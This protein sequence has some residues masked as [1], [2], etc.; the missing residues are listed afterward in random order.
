MNGVV[1]PRPHAPRARPAPPEKTAASSGYASFMRALSIR[2]PY[3]EEILR[4]IKTVEYRTRPTKIIDKRF[5]IYAGLKEP[6]A[7]QLARFSRLYPTVEALRAADLPKGL[8]VGTAIITGNLPPG[9]GGSGNEFWG[10]KLAKV[11]RMRRPRK[12]KRQ[13]QPTW[14]NPF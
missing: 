14:F 12:P 3:A 2:Q 4:G 10:W 1:S 5:Y 8:I 7:A 13:P 9:K 11:K 6:P